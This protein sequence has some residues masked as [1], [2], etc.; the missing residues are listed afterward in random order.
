MVQHHLSIVN[1]C[2]LLFFKLKPMKYRYYK[3]LKS[4]DEIRI[5]VHIIVSIL[6]IKKKKCRN[7]TVDG[8]KIAQF[9]VA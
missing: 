4:L 6:K 5:T 3:Y 8:Y 7:R 2:V 9:D 1:L